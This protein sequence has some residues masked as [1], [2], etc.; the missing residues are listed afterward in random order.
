MAPG[1]TPRLFN[2][3][4]RE[5]VELRPAQPGKVGLYTCGMTVYADP[6]LGNMRPYV[7]SDTL[8]R[9]LEWKGL[10]VTQVV[11]ITDVGHTVGESDLGEDKVELAARR[12]E[13]SVWDVTRHYT[14]IF[15]ADLAALNVLPHSFN[16]RASDYIPQM[17]EFAQVLEKRGFT[18][19]LDSGLYF[20]TAKSEGYGRLALRSPES[21]ASEIA[22][23]TA[24]PGKR[25]PADFAV[26]RAEQGP[27]QRLVH[28][29]SPWGPGVP[30]WHLECSV[31][32]IELLGRH[33]DMH[34]GGVD[35]R[36]IHH[37][38]E[39]AQSEAY[40][41]DGIDWVPL[42]MHNEWLLLGNQKISK[43]SGRMPVLRDLTEAGYHPLAYRYFLL[44][45]HYRNQLDLTDDGLRAA[46]VALRRLLGRIAPL[47]PLPTVRTLEQARALLEGTEALAALERVDTAIS[48]D[49]NTARLIAELN[50]ILRDEALTDPQKATLIAAVDW[51]T[52]LRLA[53]LQP[54]DIT[55]ANRSALP[56]EYIDNLVAE[57]SAARNAGNW[58]EADRIREQLENLGVRVVDTRSGTR[59]E[60][61]PV[62]PGQLD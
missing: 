37:V 49:L 35:H 44:T 2:S 17:I 40:L 46:T 59:W 54:E 39:I 30:G 19:R 28:W 4:G 33:F 1:M 60:P 26:W 6:H 27:Q 50:A 3:L 53:E 62:D 7:F 31:M 43:S 32:S 22:R 5:L 13:T 57:R 45:A 47:R 9:M 51:L 58:S 23:V 55:V 61:I 8:R 38:N 12:A 21:A 15:F 42:W 52:G 48:D 29:D 24:D 16:P 34:T 14:E 18:Y 36:E 10:E 41:D 56:E 11:N 25:S 20:D